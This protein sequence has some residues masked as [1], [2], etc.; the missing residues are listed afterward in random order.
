MNAYEAYQRYLAFKQHFT[1]K[2]YDIFKYGGKVR[3]SVASFDKRRDKYY[4]HKLSK[5]EDVDGLL[6]AFFVDV[7]GSKGW[8]GDI[9]GKKEE[10]YGKWLGRQESLTYRFENDVKS[11]DNLRDALI[12]KDGQHPTLLVDFLRGK[13]A[14][15]TLIVLDS[16]IKMFETWN[17]KIEDK[18]IWPRVYLKCKKYQPFVKFN[19]EKIHK[20]LVDLAREGM[21]NDTVTS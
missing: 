16:K 8:I 18:L 15:E 7:V 3:S 1:T 14:I 2:D 5:Q 9:L 10:Y 4:F 17:N 6:T 12:V 19:S 21:Y 13:I 20:I 11:Y